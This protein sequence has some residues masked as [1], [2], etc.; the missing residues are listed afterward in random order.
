MSS[1]DLIMGAAGASSGPVNYVDDVFSTYLYTGNGSTQT[2]TNGIDLA[3][4]G[5]MVWIKSRS[6]GENHLVVDTVRGATN[7]I[8]PNVTNAS[9]SSSTHVTSFTSSGFVVDLDNQVNGTSLGGTYASWTFRE[10]PKFFDIVTYTGNATSGTVINHNLGSVPG[11]IILKNTTLGTNWV[12]HHR[13]VGFSQYLQLNTTIAATTASK[14]TNSTST[15]FTISGANDTNTLGDTFVAYLFAHNAGGFGAAGTDNVISC[16]SYTGTGSDGNFINL[17]YEPQYIL[18]KRATVAASDWLVIDSARGISYNFVASLAPNTTAG[19]TD[20]TNAV[21]NATGFSINGAAGDWNASGSSYIYMAIRRPMK[22]PTSSAEVFSPVAYTGTNVDNRLV[23]TGIVTDMVMARIRASESSLGFVTGDR[24]RGNSFLGTAVTNAETADADS[25]MTPTVGYGNPFSA[26]NGF[27]VGNDITR[28][29]NNSSTTQLA[30]AF[31]RA[32]GFFD[33]VCYTGTGSATDP[34]NHNLGTI[35]QLLIIK[36]RN[37]TGDWFVSYRNAPD[38]PNYLIGNLNLTDGLGSDTSPATDNTA[39]TFKPS[40]TGGV[41]SQVANSGSTYVAY[42]FASVAGVSK[43]GSYTGTGAT[44]TINCGFTAGA[45]FVM[46]KRT[47]A[48]GNWF[49][50]DTARGIT[51][52]NDIVFSVNTTSV[53][54]NYQVLSPNSSGFALDMSDSSGY[55][56]V[57]VNVSGATYIYLAIA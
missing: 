51:A 6:Q 48:A 23:N 49:V 15:T 54:Q 10:A 1:T 14:I 45:R 7:R 37:T 12:V 38:F 30:Y 50:W 40:T 33:V 27:G 3:G 44:Q 42:L 21:V 28:K 22:S 26:M 56:N 31:K 52:D 25:L 35:P 5:G 32:T 11:M 9:V 29:L 4:K 53:E 47:D 13:S 43:V 17:G 39:T 24:L 46:I 41:A 20:S 8:Q 55:T 57:P 19:E 16:G 2:I 18:L 36:R 34:I